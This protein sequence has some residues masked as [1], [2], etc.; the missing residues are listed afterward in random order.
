MLE[1][2]HLVNQYRSHQLDE[3]AAFA[4]LGEYVPPNRK[5]MASA[6]KAS[7]P[8][9]VK[10]P[11]KSPSKAPSVVDVDEFELDEAAAFAALPAYKPAMRSVM[12]K[13]L[14]M[15]SVM[16]PSAMKAVSAMKVE[17]PM[18]AV[19]EKAAFAALGD[20]K[21]SMKMAMNKKAVMKPKKMKMVLSKFVSTFYSLLLLR[22]KAKWSNKELQL[23]LALRTAML[24]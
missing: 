3:A 24:S 18:K 6:M 1:L 7:S 14:K 15:V 12:K 10:S 19:D 13:E 5:K 23:P 11:S 4:A 2:F 9:M 16:K 17:K 20:Y 22:T 8:V 21:P